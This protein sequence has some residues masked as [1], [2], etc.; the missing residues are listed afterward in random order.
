MRLSFIILYFTIGLSCV[1]SQS[2]SLS[3]FVHD[4]EN[5][6]YLS[7][8]TVS[9]QPGDRHLQ[10]DVDGFFRFK[11]LSPSNY[12]LSI[13]FIGYN[14]LLLPISLTSD[15]LLHLHLHPA[16]LILQEVRIEAEQNNLNGVTSS[17]PVI[18]IGRNYLLRNSSTNFIQTL[19]SIAG[20]SSMDIGAGFSKPVIRGLG[21][22]RVAV[23]D[24]GIVQQNQQ[25][26][27]DHGL[28]IDQFDVDGVRLHKG[29]MS[30]YFGSDAIGGVI[31]IL[32][33]TIPQNDMFWGDATIIA[34]S[35]NDLLGASVVASIKKGKL[36]LR[37]R[38]TVQSYG[39]YKI[40]TDT[41][42]YQTWEM[43]IH[44]RR[45]KNSAGR[46]YNL[47]L[48]GNYSNNI[49]NSWLHISNMN[50]KNGFFPGAH[51]IPMLE[52]LQHDGSIRNIEL[53]YATSNHFKIVSNS[54]WEF[55]KSSKLLF[56]VGYQ[57]NWREEL[58]EFHTHYGNQQAPVVDPDLELR[59]NLNT[60]SGSVKYVMDEDKTWSKIFGVS[61]EY[62]HNRV[63]GF[64][65]LLPDFER[66][67]SGVF[68]INNFK[69]NDKISLTGG[70]RYDTGK[71]NVNEFYDPMLSE[72]L[73]MQN[74][75]Q[76][77]ADFYALRSSGLIRSFNDISGSIGLEYLPS[78]YH[79]IKL[80]IGK[81]F[82]YPG[83]NELAS[84]GLHH[85]AF[86]HE[87]GNNN[88]NSEKGYQ[89][90]LDYQ[91]QKNKFSLMLN[92]FIGWFENYIYLE[93]TG[94]WSILPHAGQIYRYNEAE[95]ILTG[96]EL[97]LGYEI[98][99]NWK[100]NADVEYVYN[101]DATD[102]YALPFTPPTV[103]TTS[104]SYLENG[105]NQN[106]R[107]GYFEKWS[108]R[109]ISINNYEIKIE[110]RWILDQNSISRNEL[111]TPGAMLWNISAYT[112]W[113]IGSKWFVSV[114]KIDNLFNTPF[115][116]HLSFYRKLNAPEPG[117]NIQ[118]ILKVPF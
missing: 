108:G 49:F 42:N 72:Y 85:G 38:A 50:S 52:R 47:A 77:Y 62:Q 12:M 46:E 54:E 105:L 67:T 10:A 103:V 78:T 94:S 73:V 31:E 91:F 45:M 48:S 116:N 113:N 104:L 92:P 115:M 76:E 70:I 118:L 39:D 81:S 30:L 43:P 97:M 58:S 96:G 25:W 57:Q 64:S 34:K 33:A 35:N 11:D 68:W 63:G 65:F 15:T 59:F 98:D 102:S 51:G 23:V 117:R 6:S 27:A 80:N 99:D 4:Y 93:P 87:Q 90:D 21:F 3:G 40:P 69:L 89:L 2:Y 22:N 14:D 7:A 88:L 8:A 86:R 75:P 107:G 24:K 17:L 1:F 26:G 110:N 112:H 18:E 66:F 32:P 101:R 109:R 95:A 37:G 79:S 20:V 36:F 19:S 5:N 74:Y 55:S 56:D 84:N 28:E 16:P 53:P 71:L 100:L 106:F 83:A 111:T 44:E 9:L 82:R 41:I 60:Y 114:L 13:S 61:S 29:P